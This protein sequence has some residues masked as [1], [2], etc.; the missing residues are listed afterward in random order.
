[1]ARATGQAQQAVIG[2]DAIGLTTALVAQ[3]AGLRVRVCARERPPAVRSSFATGLWSPDWRVCTSA[4]ATPAF[5]RRRER[6]ARSSFGIYQNLLGLPGDPIEW[7]DGDVLSDVPFDR[8][9][10]HGADGGPDYR[11]LEARRLPTCTRARSRRRRAGIR[12]RC[13]TCAAATRNWRSTSAPTRG[14]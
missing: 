11:P 9:T 12:S 8:P 2:C 14:C 4:Y 3:R 1:M 6:M 13:S 5:A 10:A 7:R